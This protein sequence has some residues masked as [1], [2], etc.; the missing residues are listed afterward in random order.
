MASWYH[1]SNRSSCFMSSGSTDIKEH[2]QEALRILRKFVQRKRPELW[3]NKCWILHSFRIPPYWTRFPAIFYSQY[4]KKNLKGKAIEGTLE[5]SLTELTVMPTIELF[6]RPAINWIL[7]KD[8]LMNVLRGCSEKE[9]I[10]TM[11]T[12]FFIL[13]QTAEAVYCW[14]NGT[15]LL[16]TGTFW[17]FAKL[18]REVAKFVFCKFV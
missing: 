3:H 13:F 6:I 14:G 1:R 11:N 5:N 12:D 15:D 16:I 8:C 10:F 9:I 4:Y 7:W 17:F 2:C 18:N